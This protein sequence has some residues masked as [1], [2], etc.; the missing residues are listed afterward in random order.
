MGSFSAPAVSVSTSTGGVTALKTAQMTLMSSTVVS[1]LSATGKAVN[2]TVPDVKR[3]C[4]Q[5]IYFFVF[6][7]CFK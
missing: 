5:C 1:I 6:S 4:L 7:E 2:F 3:Q